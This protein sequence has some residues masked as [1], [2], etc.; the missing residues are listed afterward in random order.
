MLRFLLLLVPLLLLLSPV[1][2]VAGAVCFLARVCAAGL[3]RKRFLLMVA[4]RLQ[5]FRLLQVSRMA[6]EAGEAGNAIARWGRR[7]RWSMLC[8]AWMSCSS[9]WVPKEL[10]GVGAGG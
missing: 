8:W 3:L 6:R 5:Q 10:G 4:A 7:P 1:A 2:V 9:C